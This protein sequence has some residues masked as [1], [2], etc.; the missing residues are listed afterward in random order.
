[1]VLAARS[2]C[3]AAMRSAR[4]KA[5]NT[6]SALVV[7]VVAAQVVDVHRDA[8]V[9]DEALEELARQVHVEAADRARVNSR[10]SAGPA[11]GEIDHH[12]RQR[13]VEWNVGVAVAAQALLVAERALAKAWPRVMPTSLDGVVVVDVRI[14]RGAMNV[15]VDQAVAGDLVEHV[16][17]EGHAGIELVLPAAIEVDATR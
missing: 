2:S 1:M 17:E 10:N 5:L 7:G 9:I 6:V 4:A 13:L 14:A 12:A 8:G 16:I 3:S 15:E 11:A